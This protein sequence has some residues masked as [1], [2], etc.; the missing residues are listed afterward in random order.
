MQNVFRKSVCSLMAFL[1]GF[2]TVGSN[3]ALAQSVASKASTST[4]IEDIGKQ[5]NALGKSLGGSA[6]SAAP[7]FDGTNIHFKAG[8]K[9]YAI[10]KNK[11]VPSDNGK[12]I[13]YAH[14]EED[15]ENQ[16]N[17]FD[18]S[19]AMT[20]LGSD[21]KDALFADA[22]SEKPTVEGEVYSV[23]MDLAKKEK[24]DFSD[25]VILEKTTEILGD[26]ENVLKDLVSCDANSALDSQNK[27]VHLEDLKQCQQ[28]V[29]R[30][31]TCQAKHNYIAGVL[32]H[33]DGPFNFEQCGEGCTTIWLG[34]VG[35]NYLSDGGTG[36]I[37]HTEEVLFKVWNPEAIAKAELDYAAYDDQMQVWI[38]PRGRETKVY[39]GPLATFPYS[40]TSA[41]RIESNACELDTHWIWDPY[42]NGYGCTERGCQYIQQTLKPIDISRYLKQA[43]NGGVV[44]FYLR[45]AIGDRGEAYARMRVY[46][47]PNRIVG[48][49]AWTPKT[50]L[51]A[52]LGVEDGMAKGEYKCTDMPQLDT[53]GCAY[54]NGAQICPEKMAESPLTGVNKLCREVTVTTNYDFYKGDTGCWKAMSGFDKN[55]NAVY[56]EI[57]GGE[58]LGG[59]L[60]TCTKYKENPDCKFVESKC[61]EG[62]TGASGTCYV[63]DVTYDCGKDVKVDQVHSDTTYDCKGIACLGE[64]CIDVE[65]TYSTDFSKVNALLNAAQ[66]MAQD[67][68]CDGLDE[69]GNPLGDQNVTCRVFGGRPGSCKIAV[70]GW[71]DCCEPVGGP[72]VA[73]YISMIIAAQRNHAATVAIANIP[74][75]VNGVTINATIATEMAGMYRDTMNEV[76]SVLKSGV[77]YLSN[78]FSSV[79]DNIYGN[80]DY[81]TAPFKWFKDWVYDKIMK[82][83]REQMVTI[84]KSVGIDIGGSAGAGATE[85]TMFQNALNSQFGAEVG[86]Y[87]GS[88]ISFVGWV[89]LAYQVANLVIQLVYK[90]E[91]EE[92]ETV[93]KNETKNCHYVGSYCS[94]KKLGICIVKK[95]VYCCFQSPLSR[96]MNQQLKLTQP[97]VLEKY[98]AG[99]GSW[100]SPKS[101]NCSGIPLG[102]VNEINWDLINLDEWTAL[103]VS[104]GNMKTESAKLDMDGLTGKGSELNWTGKMGTLA[105]VDVPRI[106]TDTE[107]NKDN[108]ANTAGDKNP[109]PA[110]AKMAR[111]RGAY[112]AA[113][114]T[115]RRNVLTRTEEK[116]NGVHVD[117][118]RYEST[119]C[120]TLDLGNGVTVR[121]GCGE[122]SNAV[123][124]CRQ[125]GAL[126]DCEDIAYKNALGELL[127]NK[128][129]SRDYWDEGYR[130]IK[131]DS[132][133]DCSTL[134]SKEAY[135]DAL[136]EYAKVIGGTTW[137]GRYVCL[138]KSGHFDKKICEHAMEQNYCFCEPGEFVCLD[139][140]KPI[141]C[142]V[143]GETKTACEC[144]IGACEKDCKFGGYP[145]KMGDNST[146]ACTTG[147]CPYGNVVGG[148]PNCTSAAVCPYGHK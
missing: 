105:G 20:E 27:Y 94:S 7:A 116:L 39:Q 5:A 60:D 133:I 63:N 9:D 28:V 49:D 108:T 145:D 55:G 61:T 146:V 124:V 52:A 81:L 1:V 122:L 14:T 91:Q 125:N 32:E 132:N 59:N 104:T 38:G 15:F 121:G 72:G 144:A 131:N 57:C 89:Y 66:Y 23:L 99:A 119:K 83:I 62:M 13:R 2:T 58:N 29:D 87:I 53:S 136:E 69:N 142:A 112:R 71:Q 84:L 50:C 90:C 123:L 46:F 128:P 95:R 41:D 25:D 107:V 65:R 141:S 138:D 8:D 51:D 140:N 82:Y 143:L 42:G 76:A 106:E 93:S 109:V 148:K 113:S 77:D 101:P 73:E 75:V 31:I 19:D 17:L 10:D 88:A 47:D 64:S 43:G 79:M 30:S 96:I 37:L 111:A 16:K 86:G 45:D 80:M 115:D 33:V 36:C 48:N 85:S 21:Q 135:E 110:A 68:E 102:A 134:W 117:E 129:N 97:Q 35:N 130:C 18:D 34:K 114:R 26:M 54:I 70:G 139:G 6:K 12:N 44:R 67:M 118:L 98:A 92:Y 103:L 11:L 74:T 40:D 56:E 120:I 4:S 147:N 22:E 137:L 100:G 126:V 127:G 24:P 78:A 3:Y